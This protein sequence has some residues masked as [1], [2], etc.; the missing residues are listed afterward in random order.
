MF[1]NVT[2]FSSFLTEE[3]VILHFKMEGILTKNNWLRFPPKSKEAKLK[4]VGGDFTWILTTR[5]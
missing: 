1:I 2:H 4:I 3:S 5:S